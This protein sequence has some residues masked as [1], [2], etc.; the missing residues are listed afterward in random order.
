MKIEE[1]K[2]E[3]DNSLSQSPIMEIWDGTHMD[4]EYILYRYSN[5]EG[6]L[7]FQDYDKFIEEIGSSLGIY[8]RLWFGIRLGDEAQAM[9]GSYDTTRGQQYAPAYKPTIGM[10]QGAGMSRSLEY[11]KAWYQ[12]K[13]VKLQLQEFLEE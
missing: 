8:D 1:I 2:I 13:V 6:E 7:L 12:K 9:V 5:H 10:Q 11:V 3:L 4:I